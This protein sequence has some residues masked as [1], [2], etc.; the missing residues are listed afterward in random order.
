MKQKSDTRT[1]FQILLPLSL[2]PRLVLPY[3]FCRQRKR[4]S[5]VGL[6]FLRD[7]RTM[8]AGKLFIEGKAC[9]K[10]GTG[11]KE[12]EIKDECPCQLKLN[13]Y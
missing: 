4:E 11:K 10:K 6:F 3:L 1:M 8:P 2:T 5:L 9:M 7:G 13:Y 12:R